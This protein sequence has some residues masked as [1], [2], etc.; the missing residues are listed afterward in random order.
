MVQEEALAYG[1]MFA[2]SQSPLR[3]E[4][5]RA[6]P[7]LWQARASRNEATDTAFLT[8]HCMHQPVTLQTC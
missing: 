1:A 3:C 6:V 2:D 7:H 8:G 5:E 4:V